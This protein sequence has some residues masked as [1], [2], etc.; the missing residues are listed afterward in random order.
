[1][2]KIDPIYAARYSPMTMINNSKRAPDGT[3]I[4]D[5]REF[6]ETKEDERAFYYV[7]RSEYK[8]PWKSVQHL[9]AYFDL[10]DDFIVGGCYDTFTNERV[11]KTRIAS[12]SLCTPHTYTDEMICKLKT[13]IAGA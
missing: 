7:L 13:I 3:L 5:R 9:T 6:V 2:H 4:F 1:M 8:M 11:S 12:T 10:E